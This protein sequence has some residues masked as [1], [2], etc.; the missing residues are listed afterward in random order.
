MAMAP[1]L[2]AT[3]AQGVAS[4]DRLPEI[5]IILC[6]FCYCFCCFFYYFLQ[7]IGSNLLGGG[8]GLLGNLL[9]GGVFGNLLG[10]VGDTVKNLF[11]GVG[12]ILS[13]G[14]IVSGISA[15]IT[16]AENKK[17][18]CSGDGQL[19][20]AVCYKDPSWSDWTC[21]SAD[22]HDTFTNDELKG[23]SA[24]YI[25]G[26]LATYWNSCRNKTFTGLCMG[27][28]SQCSRSMNCDSPYIYDGSQY[29]TTPATMVDK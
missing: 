3:T 23:K 22:G 4:N 10:G 19:R 17:L 29:C 5:L 1:M 14:G 26:K 25:T 12:D 27:G 28:V 21:D 9:G 13:G 2:L 16:A 6:C 15:G 11:G 24:P 8:N 18:I 7:N 20:G